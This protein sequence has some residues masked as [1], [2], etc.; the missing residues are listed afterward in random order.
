MKD[1]AGAAR[2]CANLGQA[3]CTLGHYETAIQY[4]QQDLY[5]SNEVGDR[6]GERRAYINL[7]NTYSSQG[8][9]TKAIKYYQLELGIAKELGDRAGEASTF[10][11]LGLACYFCGDLNKASQYHQLHLNAARDV[12]DRDGEACACNNLG[13]TYRNLADFEKAIEHFQLSLSI[14]R[15]LGDREGEGNACGNL[16]NVYSNR[17]D[18]WK[19]IEHYQMDLSIA[20]EIG[21]KISE[22]QAYGNLGVAYFSLSNFNKAIEYHQLSL[23]IAKEVGHRCGEASAYGNLG[24]AY[25]YLGQFKEAIEYHK[26]HLRIAKGM[27]DKKGEGA[28]YGNLGN[29]YRCLGFFS[30]ALEYHQQHLR[31]TKEVGDRFGEGIAR[32]NL[33]V[34]YSNL[35]DFEMAI[36]CH[37]RDRDISLSVGDRAGEGRAYGNLAN[38]YRDQG[39]LE[40]AIDYY[41]RSIDIVKEVGDRAREG[42][43]YGN[44]GSAYHAHGKLEESLDCHQKHLSIA[45][46][47]GEKSG[48]ASAYGNLGSVYLSQGNFEK[49]IEYYE[50]F[51]TYSKEMRSEAAEGE[52]HW[53]LGWAYYSLGDMV[54]AERSFKSSVEKL[55]DTTDG[56]KDDWIISLFNYCKDRYTVLWII[57]LQ[58][59]KIS[60]ALSTAERG[61]GQAL[62]KLMEMQYGLKSAP[63][64]SGEQMG[65]TS[66]IL[67]YVSSETVFLAVDPRAINFWVIHKGRIK[68]FVRK[69]LDSKTMKE[70]ALAYLVS[71]NDDAYDKIGVLELLQ[72]E[73]AKQPVSTNVRDDPLGVFYD[74]LITPIADFIHG[75][76]LTIVPDGPLFLA[77]FAAFKDQ[78]ASYLSER[79]SLRLIPT[80]TTL[81][82]I[83]ESSEAHQ[84]TTGALL[85]GDPWLGNIRIKGKAPDQ[86]P[87]AK[88]EVQIIGKILK[89][90]PLT[91]KNA[92]KAEVLRRLST[93]ALVHIAAHGKEETG[94]IILSPNP[95]ASKRPQD[96]D[97]L[98]TMEDVK[99]AKL[100]ARLVVLS[101]CCSGR[102]N[103]KAEGVVGI[104][105]AFLGAGARSVLA[106]LWNI[107][108]RA[109]LKFM[110]NF[111]RQLVEEKQSASKSLNQAMKLMR[112]SKDFHEVRHWAPFVL[113]GDDVSLDFGETL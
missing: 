110:E 99:N 2:M 70:S 74:L 104:A 8:D 98:L 91:D 7:G 51:L 77:P 45:S 11:S 112:E 12:K 18:F 102:G 55:H 16:G 108:D 96:K 22:L 78:H 106:S 63:S 88:K 89:T 48:Q 49:A 47:V 113:I 9:F 105:R 83:G 41:Q 50:L 59:G 27:Q 68:Q 80:L 24:N 35:G 97:Y 76:D 4:H 103:I 40:S 73:S 66:D 30:K 14:F 28:A 56:L 13:I 72:G 62:M 46:E 42:S 64:G 25:N 100:N 36:T 86:L 95:T 53:K 15:E 34:G 87:N 39:D 23:R 57:L 93:V 58:Q 107:D 94:E 29:A 32:S 65:V 79:L 3:Y 81:K 61:R 31:I 5:I 17:G 20:K 10:E 75:D 90:I 111:Y 67:K 37:K 82:I 71:L 52:A 6:A 84:N 85:V 92:T 33:G 26:L 101:C 38:T 43:T 44:L 54:K 69:E 19:A 21:N 1:R 109:T 60:E